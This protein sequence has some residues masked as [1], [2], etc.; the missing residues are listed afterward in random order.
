MPL[1]RKRRYTKL[2]R[3][4]EHVAEVNTELIYTDEGWSPHLSLADAERLDSVRDALRG[5]DVK[6]AIKYA[7]VYSLTPIAL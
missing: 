4:G 7:R 2:I 3:V 5:G 1:I 6:T